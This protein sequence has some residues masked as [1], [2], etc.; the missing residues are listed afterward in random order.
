MQ[1]S[2]TH[3]SYHKTACRAHTAT[4]CNTLQHTSHVTQTACRAP[5]FQWHGIAVCCS[6]LQCAAVC[7]SVLQCTAVCCTMCC[8]VLQYVAVCVAVQ[9]L[10]G[11]MVLQCL[12]VWC[13]VV[14]CC[15]AAVCYTECCIVLLCVAVCVAVHRP[16]QSIMYVHFL[17]QLQIEWR[18]ILKLFLKL[19]QRTRILPMG[20]TISII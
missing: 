6:V 2:A 20:F 1:H 17:V 16:T 3:E 14:V 10:V 13:S 11:G 9:L 4:H 7:C 8:N 5:T 12:A 18:R 15:I 19:C